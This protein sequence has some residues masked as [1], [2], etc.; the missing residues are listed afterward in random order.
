MAQLSRAAQDFTRQ[1]SGNPEHKTLSFATSR[2][3]I[4]IS[5]IAP[6]Q[7]TPRISNLIFEISPLATPPR[8]QNYA[9]LSSAF[10]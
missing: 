7:V 5:K 8:T 2:L 9:A 10:Y 3:D 4:V 6:P 1:L